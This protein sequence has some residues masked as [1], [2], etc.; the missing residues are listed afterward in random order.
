MVAS[1]RAKW[2]LVVF[3]MLAC[4]ICPHVVSA[5]GDHKLVFRTLHTP[6][7]DVH[8]HEPLGL[9]AR[10]VAAKAE[11]IYERVTSSLGLGVRQRVQIILSDADD[12][13]NGLAGPLPYN[14]IRLRA[15][16]PDDMSVLS[17]YDDWPT[18]LLTHELT[19]IVH[20][21]HAT[22][23]PRLMQRL[24]GRGYTPQQFLPGWFVEGI[25]V[26]EESK[27]T[28]GGRSRDS[29]FDMF[30]RMDALEDRVLGLDWIA[31]EGE[32]WPHGNVRYVY[33]EGLVGFI[34][35]RHGTRALG[36]FIEEY[37]KRLVPYGVNRAMQ[38]A[39]GE[40]VVQLYDAF[41]ADLRASAQQKAAEVRARGLLEGE[42]LTR[43]GE[44][45]RNPRYLDDRHI[46][47]GAADGRHVTQLSLLDLA[48][49][50][51]PSR[52]VVRTT[53]AAAS[54]KIPGQSQFLYSAIDYHR[55]EY[56]FND[57]FR[58]DRNGSARERLTHGM[59]AREP[60]VSRDGRHVVYVVHGAGTSHLEI[61]ELTDI[62]GTRRPL[63]QSRR[64]EQVFTPRFSPD[65]STVAYGAWSRGGYRDI[66]LVDVA[67]GVRTRLTNDRAIDRGPVFSSDGRT[68]Y[69]S[70][71]RTSIANLYAYEFASGE[72]RQIT[73]VIG[74]AFQPDVSPDGRSLVYVGYTS[75]GFDLY[76]LPLDAG[77]SF[78]APA[79]FVRDAPR[80]FESPL[81]MQSE[82]Y[83]PLPT[84]SPRSW[85]L[86][87]DEF[88]NEGRVVAS[89][90][91]R[92]AVAMHAWSAS[93]AVGLETGALWINSGYSYLRPRFP[94]FISLGMARRE[95][96][97]LV[98]NR[99][100]QNWQALSYGATI[101]TNMR[102]PY[103]IHAFSVR[104][105][106]AIN[107]LQQR[108]PFEVPL[109][110]NSAPPLLPVLGR[111]ASLAVTLAHSNAQRQFYDISQS[112]GH[113]VSVRPIVR[114]EVIGS[115]EDR[116][117]VSYRVEQFVRLEVQESV[118]AIAYTGAYNV[119]TNVGGFPAQLAP[120][121]DTLTGSVP[122]P[123][124]YARL[125]GFTARTGSRL[126]VLQLEARALVLR[127][128]RGFDTLPVFA[129][130]LHLAIFA[131]AGDAYEGR[132]DFQR[133][134]LGVGGELRFDVSTAYGEELTF[135]VGIAQGLTEGGELQWYT[136]LA[137]PF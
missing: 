35:R 104:P 22:G 9:W 64:M 82:P 13:A 108:E 53:S 60:D 101:G 113:S 74:G 93:V 89:T 131:D 96:N 71:D 6:H 45:V 57:L 112:W 81:V 38:R 73:N 84:L 110:P 11:G 68:L 41:K 15:V 34:A 25:A 79:S 91:G 72:M 86:A 124:D 4:A 90:Y 7:F 40:S 125:R 8:Y 61:A 95:R 77:R 100:R 130:R 97:D 87:R 29:L 37:G 56:A 105:E 12:A 67:S 58:V 52:R 111:D 51:A 78:D 94:V 109:D 66:W 65:G 17:D 133:L 16:A 103:G 14:T 137:R 2:A 126:S 32:P 46:V 88:A 127:I 42:R 33:G 21:E 123:A 134:A 43:Q 36:R 92:D 49:P 31:F 115:R 85:E 70:S 129:R 1:G 19:H 23:L 117:G 121:L 128:N 106:Y 54:S 44:L 136:S 80:V 18:L 75:K 119:V 132:L 62:S 26:V 59:R 76:R 3:C 24:F 99:L 107:T 116:W 98:A 10:D 55:G 122:A 114:N 20:L 83:N 135:R 48:K 47:Y 102:F 30:L 118:L 63:V 50:E 5:Q 120:L 27:E 28:T 69:F 39:T